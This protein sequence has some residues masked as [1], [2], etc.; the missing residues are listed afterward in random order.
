MTNCRD[1]LPRIMTIDDEVEVTTVICD[2]FREEGYEITGYSDAQ[3][4]LRDLRESTA[5]PDVILVDIMMPTIDG[6]EFSRRLQGEPQLKNIPVI[7]LTG[8]DRGD[9]GLTFLRS[10]GQLYVKKP[11]HLS[12][13]KNLIL[14]STQVGFLS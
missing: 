3:A 13:L 2:Y 1:K 14:L 9:D 12:E 8:K 4:A 7:F 11:F 5:L 6:Y 10:G